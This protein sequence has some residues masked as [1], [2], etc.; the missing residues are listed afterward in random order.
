MQRWI[1]WGL[2]L[3]L[4][5]AIAAGAAFWSSANAQTQA[6]TVFQ[7]DLSGSA[8][9]PPVETSATGTFNATVQ[10]DT[11][12]YT[13][14]LADIGS[15]TKVTLHTGSAAE[16]GPTAATLF[17]SALGAIATN[18]TGRIGP[19]D[20]SA[21]GG[22][23]FNAMV[24]AMQNGNTYVTVATLTNLNGEIRGQITPQ[25]EGSGGTGGNTGSA[26]GGATVTIDLENGITIQ[27]PAIAIDA[28]A[29]TLAL[30]SQF[31]LATAEQQS[32]G[33]VRSETNGTITVTFQLNAD[34][35]ARFDASMSAKAVVAAR[36]N[37]TTVEW[38]PVP[39][40][41]NVATGEVQAHTDLEGTFRILVFPLVRIELDAAWNTATFT[42]ASGTAAADLAADL[43]ANVESIWRFNAETGTWEGWQA[44]LLAHL[45][46]LVTLEQ[47]DALFIK[48]EGMASAEIIDV[49]PGLMPDRSV[50]L[51]SG[52]NFVA[53][54]GT[55][56]SAQAS[57]AD[58]PNLRAAFGYDANLQVWQAFWPGR[59][60]FLSN[61]QSVDRLEALFIFTDGPSV[62]TY[63]EAAAEAA[64]DTSN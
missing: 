21:G 41:F 12:T 64:A 35:R 2:P 1:V 29:G 6:A 42:G 37:E 60:A 54:T 15:V 20:L 55:A 47:H 4:A 48:A 62:W 9:V 19:L 52:A 53:F 7:A 10:G 14:A 13:L 26:G 49:V 3:V 63:T 28:P 27:I 58:I 33:V 5:I 39:G 43:G 36:L 51:K 59:P 17:S 22:V 40:E 30:G 32:G 46:T 24:E 8:V 18:I 16:N 56:G 50:E 38:E 61:L 25:T 34:A 23:D 31:F 44:R 45:N 11:L 57:L